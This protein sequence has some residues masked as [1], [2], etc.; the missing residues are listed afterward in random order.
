MMISTLSLSG[1]RVG[2]QRSR[3]ETAE[4][5]QSHSGRGPMFLGVVFWGSRVLDVFLPLYDAG[6]PHNHRYPEQLCA[7]NH[8]D[9]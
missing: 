9:C 6:L 2:A 8:Y 1:A 7:R 5:A 4:R 3:A